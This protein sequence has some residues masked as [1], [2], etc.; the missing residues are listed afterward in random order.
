[1]HLLDIENHHN[2]HPTTYLYLEE[3]GTN[4]YFNDNNILQ[5]INKLKLKSYCE[6]LQHQKNDRVFFDF[7]KPPVLTKEVMDCIIQLCHIAYK[8]LKPQVKSNKE[9]K[10]Y[11][12]VSSKR[13]KFTWA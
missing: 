2:T 11:V 13:H 7:D 5:E 1:M 8:V 10:F 3:I 6:V 12:S 4:H 9:V